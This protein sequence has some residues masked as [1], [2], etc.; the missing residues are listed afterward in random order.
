MTTYLTQLIG[1][2]Q[3]EALLQRFTIQELAARPEYLAECKGVGPVTLRAIRA[4]IELA[5]E[6]IAGPPPKH[7]SGPGD[8]A[9]YFIAHG[10]AQKEQEELW[11]LLLNTKNR[12][13]GHEMIYRGNVNTSI[14]RV[15]EVLRPAVLRNAT[16]FIIAHNH[17]SGDATPSPQDLQMSRQVLAAAEL[18]S[19]ELLDS[20]IIGH[21]H[22]KSLKEMGL[23]TS[24]PKK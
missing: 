6:S 9:N 20:L 7:I 3:S 23:L 14:V 16:A 8:A 1:T 5:N 13:V 2:E 11:V 22:W 21:G 19:I 18:L 12:P 17:P 10:L 4:G 24:P 15:C